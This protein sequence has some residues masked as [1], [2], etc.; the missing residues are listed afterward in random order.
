MV[1]SEFSPRTTLKFNVHT[2]SARGPGEPWGTWSFVKQPGLSS[3][4]MGSTRQLG[5]GAHSPVSPKG[6]F[7]G[8]LPRP[9]EDRRVH[10]TCKV[11]NVSASPRYVGIFDQCLLADGDSDAVLL[12]KL[13]IAPGES[14]PT[15]YP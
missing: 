2:E 7:M 6:S 3:P 9:V 4:Q 14:D 13:R 12:A 8:P 10:Y 5:S 1:V 11:S 15:L